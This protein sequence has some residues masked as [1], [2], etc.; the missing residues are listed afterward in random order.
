MGKIFVTTMWLLLLGC[1][2]YSVIIG[3]YGGFCIGEDWLANPNLCTFL[4]ENT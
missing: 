3:I 1:I 2:I 4:H